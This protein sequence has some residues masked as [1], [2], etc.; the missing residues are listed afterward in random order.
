MATVLT[1]PRKSGRSLLAQRIV[2]KTGGR[3]FDDAEDHDE[4][5]IFHAWNEAQ[6]VR[7]PLILIAGRPAS[8]WDIRLPD[9]ASRLAATPHVAIGEPDDQ[10]FAS[11]LSKLLQERGLIAPPEL[12]RYLLPRVDR[13]YLALHNVVEALD[14]HLL[15]RRARLT[16]PAAKRALTEAGLIDAQRRAG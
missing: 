2:A 11:L 4:E 3:L 10:L 6:E 12:A 9:L 1:G 5:R 16:V 13:S 8:T 7:R 14:I 15:Q